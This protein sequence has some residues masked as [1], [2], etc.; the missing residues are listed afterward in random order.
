MA[1]ALMAS[2]FVSQQEES[3]GVVVER[4][5]KLGFTTRRGPVGL[6]RNWNKTGLLLFARQTSVRCL[7]FQQS[8]THVHLGNALAL[9]YLPPW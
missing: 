5:K 2:E 7:V 3:G 9:Y 1:V 8:N 4:R 6:I